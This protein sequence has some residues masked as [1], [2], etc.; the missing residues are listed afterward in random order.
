MTNRLIVDGME[1][2]VEPRVLAVLTCLYEHRNDVVTK[3]SLIKYVWQGQV[4]SDNAISRAISQA[5]KLLNQSSSPQPKIDTIPRIGYRLTLHPE[6]INRTVEQLEKT[7]PFITTKKSAALSLPFDSSTMKVIIFTVFSLA[8]F[9]RY[10]YDMLSPVSIPHDFSQTTLTQSP[11]IEK[12]AKFSADGEYVAYASV[13]GE[14][15]SEFLYLLELETGTTKRLTDVPAYIIDFSWSPDSKKIVFSHWENL[16]NRDCGVSMIKLNEDKAVSQINMIFECSER[17]AVHLAWNSDSDKIFFNAR[18]SFDRPYSISSMSLNSKRVEQ[19]TLPP[20]SGNYRGDYYVS[21]NLNGS[22][23]A[24][25]RYLGLNSIRVNI[26]STTNN[27][28]IA[29]HLLDEDID[30]LSW[31]GREHL[32][33]S[34]K[35]NLYRFNFRDKTEQKYYSIGKNAGGLSSDGEGQRVLFTLSESDI[36][37][38]K[39]F[40]TQAEMKEVIAE[41]SATEIMPSRSNDGSKLAFLSNRSGLYQIWILNNDGT[42]KQLTQSPESLV[43]SPLVWSSDDQ[44]ILFQHDDEIFSTD[45]MSG[46]IKREIDRSH[47]VANGNW[48]FDSKIIYY[49]SEKSGDWQ[50]WQYD[51][52]NQQHMQVTKEGGYSAQQSENGDLY[53]SRIH[54]SGLWVLKRDIQNNSEF[55]LPEKIIDN[56]DGTNWISWQLFNNKIYYFG[57]APNQDVSSK[58]HGVMS[59]DIEQQI[60]NLIFPLNSSQL[61]YFDVREDSIIVTEKTRSEGS[62]Q[63]LSPIEDE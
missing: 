12:L 1:Y 6:S 13:E 57:V 33:F 58:T 59:Y 8:L 14:S 49:S 51:L 62:I 48:S 52:I 9:A 30:D 25:V 19:I 4:V 41:S 37:L 54:E 32:L 40:T 15:G 11:G 44:N 60:S 34:R 21:G 55:G 35:N 24:V 47:K 46:D 53:V 28:L 61:R 50:I 63:L 56:F 2:S 5:R 42:V 36:N 23:I 45:I 18:K 29:S 10:F 16:H 26:Y 31:L 3:S 7:K 38:V 20:Q 17:S 27:E 22:H 43:V 39:Y